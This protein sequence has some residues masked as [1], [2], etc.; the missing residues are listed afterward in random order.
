LHFHEIAVK[1][2]SPNIRGTVRQRARN[3]ER[4]RDS[5]WDCRVKL[6]Q[7]DT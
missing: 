4:I 2:A 3:H 1:S 7:K 5:G 6:V